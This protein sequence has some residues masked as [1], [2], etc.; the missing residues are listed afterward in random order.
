MKTTTSILL[1]FFCLTTEAQLNLDSLRQY[2]ENSN[3]WTKTK[4]VDYLMQTFQRFERVDK[5]ECFDLFIDST[6]HLNEHIGLT[7]VYKQF[8]NQNRI[9]K[10]IGYNLKGNY[11]LWDY[12]PI[13]TTEYHYDTT[14]VSHYD[15][16][17]SLT[18][19]IFS[20][21]DNKDRIIEELRYDN[22]LR[23]YSRIT[24]SY[25]DQQNELLITTFD[26][27]GKIHYD[28]F[29]VGIKLQIFDSVNRLIEER[30]Y[31]S[32][33]NLVEAEHNLSSSSSDFFKCEFS[34]LRREHRDNEE[35][36]KY[37]DSKNELQCE[38]DGHSIW[39]IK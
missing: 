32:E 6:G 5:L 11:F 37:Y 15:Y 7:A 10:R 2:L 4:T 39:M 31:D 22:N 13:E 27:S 24:Y 25:N 33:M 23:L 14:V 16:Q 21:K 1:I 17:F 18:E 28:K 34:I 3:T 12:S 36:T 8:D 19:K 38:S 26:G 30:Y 35:L 20:I 9:T 29:G